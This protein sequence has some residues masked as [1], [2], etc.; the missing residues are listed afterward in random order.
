M[1]TDI[2]FQVIQMILSM[3]EVWLCYQL[4]YSTLL[5]KEYLNR[6]EKAVIW[7]NIPLW[8]ILISYNRNII[9]FSHSAFL[10]GLTATSICAIAVFKSRKLLTVSLVVTGY[11]LTALLDFFFMFFCMMFLDYP[12]AQDIYHGISWIKV[13]IFLMSRLT[14]MGCFFLLKKKG[15]LFLKNISEYQTILYASSII[16]I[17]LLRRYQ[18]IMCAMVYG[19]IPYDGIDSGISL[20][21]LLLIILFGLGLYIKSLLLKKE[22]QLL[23]SKDAMMLQ[24]YQ[25]LM[26]NMETNKQKFHDLKH[27]FLVLQGYVQEKEYENLG[28]YLAEINESILGLENKI[29]TGHKIL[30]F[31]LNQKK[32]IAEKKGID[33][34]ICVTALM[35]IPLSDGDLSVLTGNLLDN[36]IEACDKMETG[37]RW[38]LFRLRKRRDMLLIEISNSIGERP[39]IKNGELMTSKVHAWMHGYGLK[40]VRQIVE[41]NE[42]VFSFLIEENVF[43]IQVSF[44]K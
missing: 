29:W 20:L 14:I 44:M 41:T 18:V 16:F 9:F 6:K 37:K 26:R 8:G 38:I 5:E 21:S 31:I 40:S 12:T 11:S 28:Q 2:L 1:M 22:N 27:Q 25:D 32:E 13:P 10:F 24:N 30:D 3:V 15:R 39:I 17:V 42:G 33:F 7:A 35:E 36:A 23:A 4:L 43:K 34:G 19:R